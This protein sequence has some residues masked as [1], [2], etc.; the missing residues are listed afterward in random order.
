MKSGI[1]IAKLESLELSLLEEN[2]YSLTDPR[3]M[4]D[5]I[6]DEERKRIHEEVQGKFISVVF[7]GTTRVGEV[8]AV[9]VR[10]LHDWK[11][12]Q[13]LAH[14]QFLQKSAKGQELDRAPYL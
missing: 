14:L 2:G 1:A 7:D 13:C 5:L 12:E 4:M 10:F 9:V 8:L 6:L 11:V 3:H